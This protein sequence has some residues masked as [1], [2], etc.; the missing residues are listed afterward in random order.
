MTCFTAYYRACETPPNPAEQ[1]QEK[2]RGKSGCKIQKCISNLWPVHENSVRENSSLLKKAKLIL[3]LK[4]FQNCKVAKCY[5]KELG[6]MHGSESHFTYFHGDFDRI[7]RNQQKVK[8]YSIVSRIQQ[9]STTQYHVFFSE[10]RNQ[11]C[12]KDKKLQFRCSIISFCHV[13]RHFAS[14]K[15]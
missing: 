3:H 4:K 11:L 15:F 9:K 12:F 8:R 14:S 7:K 13:V 5:S 1:S 2:I 6:K 10:I